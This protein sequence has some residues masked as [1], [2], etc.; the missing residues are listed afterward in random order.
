MS[1]ATT[2]MLDA[3][4]QRLATA[5]GSR[6][7]GVVLYGSIA[8]GDAGPESDIDLLVLLDEPVHLAAD[9]E[10][11][12]QAL[13]PLADRWSRRISAKPVP[14]S[15]YEAND[16]PLYREAHREGIPA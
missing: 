2:P 1:D 15:E 5:H 11:N 16:C 13:A 10:T 9:L 6:L 12:I 7:R 8:R 4:K 14:A 3:I